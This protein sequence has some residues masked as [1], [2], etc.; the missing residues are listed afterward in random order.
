MSGFSTHK[1]KVS[2]NWRLFFVRISSVKGDFFWSVRKMLKAQSC[3]N[4]EGDHAKVLS[5][6]KFLIL[7]FQSI[8]QKT[9]A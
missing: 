4:C 3:E 7:F 1:E 2:L 8:C 5:S 9:T 6:C